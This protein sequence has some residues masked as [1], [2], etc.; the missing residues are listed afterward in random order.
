[1]LYFSEKKFIEFFFKRIKQNDTGS[2]ERDFPYFSPCGRERNFVRCDDLPIV[3]TNLICIGDN[4]QLSYNWG[5]E[6]LTVD[7]E[8]ENVC[9]LPNSGRV[10]HPAMDKL[11]GVGLIKSSLAIEFSKYFEFEND[12]QNTPP[13]H[14][15]WKGNRFALTQKIIPLLE[16]EHRRSNPQM[17]G[18]W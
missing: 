3:F 15:T 1:M 4:E 13:T 8:P 7:F 11:G 12:E 5:S 17:F 6:L 18:K 14:F 9:M 10:Y 16:E 2:Y